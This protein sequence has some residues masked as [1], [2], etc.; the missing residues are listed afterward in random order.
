[1]RL[2]FP[3]KPG[4]Y[5]TGLPL[6]LVG[7]SLVLFLV[8]ATLLGVWTAGWSALVLLLLLSIETFFLPYALIPIALRL[9]TFLPWVRYDLKRHFVIDGEGR[10][11]QRIIIGALVVMS[12]MP[13][14][15]ARDMPPPEWAPDWLALPA[16]L[17]MAGRGTVV[18]FALLM[19]VLAFPDFSAEEDDPAR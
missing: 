14:M 1:M 6:V 15:G 12:G 7:L 17:L 18:F 13:I 4:L 11:I 9:P 19:V 3:A 10:L 2:P 5:W 16:I 8:S